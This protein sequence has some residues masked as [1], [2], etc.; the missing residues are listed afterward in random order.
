ML[1]LLYNFAFDSDRKSFYVILKELNH[2][3]KKNFYLKSY[4]VNL[5]YKKSSG[6]IDAYVD[7]RVYYKIIKNY[8]RSD[9]IHPI[10]TDKISFQQHMKGHKIEGTNLKAILK[11]G[12]LFVNEEV[13][14]GAEE[15]KSKLMALINSTG[16]LFIKPTDGI[17]G[18]GILKLNKGSQISFE[19]LSMDKDYVIEETL[20]QAEELD[21]IN[22]YCIN[23]LRVITVRL[24]GKIVVPNCF[25]RLG[26]GKA[27]VDNASQGGIFITYDIDEN[28]LG[29]TGYQ[30]FKNGAKSFSKHPT[31]KFVFK[32]APLPFNNEVKDLVVKA[33][34][35]FK[36]INVIGWDVGFTPNGP[37]IIEGNDN[38]HIVGMQITSHGLLNNSVYSEIF[39]EYIHAPLT[40][41]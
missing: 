41:N 3:K 24:D 40:I 18:Y 10:L 28:K 31:T 21:Q 4:F 5:M 1:G 11:G 30:L 6:H 39:K 37:V 20:T 33:A 38:P 26:R 7:E 27:P 36:N 32:D 9:G 25:L 17:G 29:S 22:P 35:S 34:E 23:T 8:Y 16:S 2:L 12:K 15:V 14:S 19:G 13:Y